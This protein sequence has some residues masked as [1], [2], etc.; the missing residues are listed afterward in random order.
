LKYVRVYRLEDNIKL[1]LK[2][3]PEGLVW[4]H[5]GRGLTETIMKCRVPYN[6]RNSLHV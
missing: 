1:G 2:I 6:A 4:V 3:G 5:M